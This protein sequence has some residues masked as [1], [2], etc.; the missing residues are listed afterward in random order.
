MNEQKHMANP[1]KRYRCA[2]NHGVQTHTVTI[3]KKP[4]NWHANNDNSQ[5]TKKGSPIM[6][7]TTKK[8]C[9]HFHATMAPLRTLSFGKK[10][11]S[12][13]LHFG[14]SEMVFFIQCLSFKQEASHYG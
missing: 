1:K 4:H 8:A 9:I 5:Q 11:S 7:E 10:P 2:G 12:Q 3:E 6:S 13:C 14:T